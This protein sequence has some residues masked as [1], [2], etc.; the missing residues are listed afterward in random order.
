VPLRVER[1]APRVV[2]SASSEQFDVELATS[3]LRLN[4][5]AGRSILDVVTAAG[6][7]T[8][9]SC[10]EGTCGSCETAVLGGEVDHRDS[11]LTPEEQEAHDTMMIC[12]SRSRSEMLIIDL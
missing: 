7:E 6:I 9:S 10:R 11:I 3:G 12:V 5:P 4:V 2:E 8:F 1:F